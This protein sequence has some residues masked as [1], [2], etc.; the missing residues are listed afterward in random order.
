MVAIKPIRTEEDLEHAL[1][2][3]DE[4]FD[5]EAG[6]PEATSLRC[7]SISLSCTS[8]KLSQWRTQ[9]PSQP[10]SFVWTRRG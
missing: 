3:I 10:L 5:A 7:L 6:T 8:P 1:A 9:V 2:R 4:I